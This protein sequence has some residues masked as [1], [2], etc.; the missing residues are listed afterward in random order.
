M[1]QR[2]EWID[3]VKA[4]SVLLVVLMHASNTMA[5]IAGG[6]TVTTAWQHVNILVEPLRM[7]MFFLVSG[8]LAAS[9]IHRPWHRT[10]N[11][12]TGMVYLYVS[13]MLFYFG[14]TALLGASQSQPIASIL[15]AK[16]GYW[17]LYA[18]AGFFVI[19]RLLR[20]QPGW[21]IVAVALVPNVVRPLTH[22]FFEGIVPGAMYTSMAMNLGFF[23]LG[24]YF[25]EALGTLASRATWAHTMALGGAALIAG[26]IWLNA[27]STIGQTYLYMSLIWVAFGVSLAVQITRHGAPTW[28]QH[29]AAR[30]LPIYVWQWPV[31][32]VTAEFLPA[33]VLSSVTAQVL[34]PA[35]FTVG[36]AVSAM[37]LHALPSLKYLFHAPVWVT[38][39]QRLR[40]VE[41]FRRPVVSPE[42]ATVTV[43]RS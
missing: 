37:W 30:T 32:F 5:D 28:A 21:L 24:A 40:I 17:Y 26:T 38:H 33:Q 22:E 43:G 6:S 20:N 36:V 12:T 9:A 29:V 11:R 25:K 7:P 31:L 14:F 10:T 41:Q 18:M 1:R 35:L 39:P 13:W 15:F 4:S 16:S 34:F 8:M 27:P 19:A 23:L 2:I 3:L 42:P